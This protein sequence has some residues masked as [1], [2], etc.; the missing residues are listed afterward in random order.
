LR[1]DDL[2][3]TVLAVA[4]ARLERLEPDVRKVLRAA[5][6]FG[7]VFWLEGV[8]ALVGQDAAAVA[9][10][11]ATL[12]EQE[13]IAPTEQPRLAG[14][15][16][17]AFRHTLLQGTAYATLTDDDRTLGHRLAAV[18]L[19][20]V[21]EDGEVVARHWLEGGDRSRAAASF[22]GAGAA[23]WAHAQADEA[24]RCALR[25][26]L[27]A[28]AAT[29]MVE[30][31]S[32][33]VRLLADALAATRSIEVGD[34]LSGMERFAP[35]P[36]A[37]THGAAL[38]YVALE[39][40]LAPLRSAHEHPSL[41]PI[42]ALCACIAG[43]LFDFTVAKEF[44]AEARAR[45]G[46]DP[47]Q[48]RST[49]YAAARIAY[50]SGETGA[51]VESVEEAVLPDDPQER[52]EML[53]ILSTA[54]VWVHGD[55]A[56]SRGL[57]FV[58]RAEALGCSGD[59]SHQDPVIRLRC[60]KAR[61]ICFHFAGDYA[62]AA[63][64]ALQAVETARS[65]GLRYVECAHLHNL[66]E[67]HLR[68]GKPHLARAALLDS[69]EIARDFGAPP[70]MKLN[71]VLLAYLDAQSD[72]LVAAAL[73]AQTANP[74]LELNAR[75]W[76]GRLLASTDPSGSRVALERALHLATELKVR[77]MADECTRALATL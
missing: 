52:L 4:Q 76:L 70:V 5:S 6:V 30:A 12:V 13:A 37:P 28:E 51:I 55:A 38:V 9:P 20:Q 58:S 44:L 72:R 40:A 15:R 7:D 36:D 31:I 74:W 23:R 62:S 3:Q 34:V 33:R 29:E 35:D 42:L 32:S 54:V 67:Q 50:W 27:V 63:E 56:L 10:I 14:V 69:N 24:A 26:L 68:L 71:A 57:D 2:P 8:C 48:Y 73:E 45:A 11:I 53:L 41:P 61:L 46:D 66:G 77:T 65:A 17:L 43:A 60:L 59:P 18:W 47:R 75:Y 25:A 49:L 16:E 19:Q 22:S 1:H 64:T 21:G 39:R